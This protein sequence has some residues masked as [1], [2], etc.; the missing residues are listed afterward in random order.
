MCRSRPGLLIGIGETRAE[1]LATL[2]AIAVAHAEHA[3]VQEVIV[4]NFRAWPGTKMADA[5]EP[6]L[7]ELR[8]TVACARLL[9]PPEVSVQAPPNLTGEFASLL[10]AGIDDF[11]G[12]SPVTIDHVNPEAPWPEVEQLQAACASRGLEL[13]PRLTVYPRYLDATWVDPAVLPRALRLA[14]ALVARP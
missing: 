6:T 1:R 9:L 14:D 11:G 8:W 5:A 13:A 10:D 7:E 2:E 4:Q 3:H 12:V